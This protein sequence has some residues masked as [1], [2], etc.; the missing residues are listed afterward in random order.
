MRP[1]VFNWDAA[2]LPA[3]RKTRNW[4]FQGFHLVSDRFL[5]PSFAFRLINATKREIRRLSCHSD[6]QQL[7]NDAAVPGG[8]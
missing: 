3:H 7:E 6:A 2:I 4:T 1:V 5:I 8:A